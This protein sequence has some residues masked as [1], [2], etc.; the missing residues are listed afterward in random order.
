MSIQAKKYFIFTTIALTTA[1]VMKNMQILRHGLLRLFMRLFF[2]AKTACVSIDFVLVFLDKGK[3][4]NNG[5][6][7]FRY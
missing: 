6:A 7:I 4:Q 2:Q 5:K 3:E 1:S